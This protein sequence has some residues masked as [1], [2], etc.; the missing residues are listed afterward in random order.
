MFEA[1]LESNNIKEDSKKRNVLLSSVG[2][3]TFQLMKKLVSS[4]LPKEKSYDVLVEAVKN[5]KSP[6]RNQIV[7]RL[8]FHL[9][10]RKDGQSALDFAAELCGKAAHCNFGDVREE[11]GSFVEFPTSE[12]KLTERNKSGFRRYGEDR[13]WARGSRQRCE[14]LHYAAGYY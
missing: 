2:L 7:A 4:A 14:E 5:H 12:F 9:M 10:E 1:Y 3:S 13:H 6:A 11:I 8:K